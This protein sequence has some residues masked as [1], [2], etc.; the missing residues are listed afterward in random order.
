MNQI[1]TVNLNTS[2]SFS[3]T[4]T[5]VFHEMRSQSPFRTLVEWRARRNY[6]KELRRLLSV[7]PHLLA[8]VRLTVDEAL[9]EISRPFWCPCN[10]LE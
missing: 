3:D 7:G 5:P 8:D 6:R 10:G 9:E 1:I 4:P 2:H